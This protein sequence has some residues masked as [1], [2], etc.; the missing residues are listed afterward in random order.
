MDKAI[1]GSS[2]RK[3]VDW[4]DRKTCCPVGLTWWADG[5]GWPGVA[6]RRPR[7][8]HPS[9][10]GPVSPIHRE[11]REPKCLVPTSEG[12]TPRHQTQKGN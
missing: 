6:P 2:W 9:M 12:R 1:F 10:S 5:E 4:E 3:L 11:G 8:G 7:Q